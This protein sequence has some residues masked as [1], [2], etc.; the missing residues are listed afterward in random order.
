MP[1]PRPSQATIAAPLDMDGAALALGVSRRTLTESLKTLPYYERRGVKKVFYPEHIAALRRGMH[2]CACAS[3]GLTVGRTP[4]APAP[5]AAAS[6][7]L[8]ELATLAKQRKPAR[9]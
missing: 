7:V 5:M 1:P 8:L 4:M 2:E 9:R 3:N 6:A